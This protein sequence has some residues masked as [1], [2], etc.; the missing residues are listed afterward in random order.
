M[1]WL[2]I[3]NYDRIL[4]PLASP[5]LTSLELR[6]H[7]KTPLKQVEESIYAL[8]STA[9]F[10]SCLRIH[11]D[12]KSGLKPPISGF[13]CLKSLVIH[14]AMTRPDLTTLSP[15]CRQTLENLRYPPKGFTAPP[16][17]T[18]GCL[19]LPNLRSL[20]LFG[21]PTDHM[22]AFVAYLRAPHVDS[23]DLE[24]RD[25]NGIPTNTLPAHTSLL[26]VVSEASFGPTLSHLTLT[27]QTKASLGS[28]LIAS[29]AVM[30]GIHPLLSLRA[31]RVLNVVYYCDDTTLGTDG[32]MLAAATAWKDMENLSFD[33]PFSDMY[34][35][36]GFPSLPSLA[37]FAAHCPRL[38]RLRIPLAFVRPPPESEPEPQA[39]ASQHSEGIGIRE[40]L[41]GPSHALRTLEVQV[42]QWESGVEPETVA[43]RIDGLFPNLG[44]DELR[45]RYPIRPRIPPRRYQGRWG[46]VI[47]AW[48]ELRAV[49]GGDVH[50]T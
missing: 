8:S 27:V 35:V 11:S 18:T 15:L 41:P 1:T 16:D 28:G 21:P 36:G 25:Q 34:E 46:L 48:K 10:L 31:L 37:H 45:F 33:F 2:E 12:N 43:Q 4:A 17:D 44:R 42:R 38:A 6:V 19:D 39:T 29:T 3:P 30:R 5:S 50:N 26:R 13:Q 49:R 23:L 7:A 22:R 9:P 40:V 47:A 20:E 14:D 32:D 24:L